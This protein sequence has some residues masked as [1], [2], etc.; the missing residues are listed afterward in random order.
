MNCTILS[1]SHP[2]LSKLVLFLL[3]LL[4]VSLANAQHRMVDTASYSR[5]PEIDLKESSAF[6]GSEIFKLSVKSD[7]IKEFVGLVDLFDEVRLLRIVVDKSTI[8]M[9]DLISSIERM[10]SLEQLS[11]TIN[12][13]GPIP[14]EL[15][16]LKG[17]RSLII[18]GKKISGLPAEI[19]NLENLES[20]VLEDMKIK[21]L[22]A[23]V[24][25]LKNLKS[26]SLYGIDLTDLSV[27][28]TCPQLT[29]IHLHNNGYSKLPE[30][31]ALM[32]KLKRLSIEAN[33]GMDFSQAFFSL[34]S[35]P[36]LNVLG[37]RNNKFKSLPSTI[38]QVRSLSILDLSSNEFAQL[39]QEVLS[40][41]NL[42]QLIIRD[43]S[44]SAL[45]DG[46]TQLKKLSTL[47]LSGNKFTTLPA[48]IAGMPALTSLNMDRTNLSDL[49][50]DLG[51][52]Q[53]LTV[54]SFIGDKKLDLPATL[55]SL[56]QL[57]KLEDL[58]MGEYIVSSLPGEIGKLSHLKSL[59]IS[60][61]LKTL[62]TEL[63]DLVTLEEL[64]LNDNKLETLPDGIRNLKKLKILDLSGNMLHAF[65][66]MLIKLPK[67]EELTLADNSMT[68]ISDYGQEAGAESP[69]GFRELKYLDLSGNDKLLSDDVVSLIA[70]LPVFQV[71]ISDNHMEYRS[72]A[73]RAFKT[74]NDKETQK[75]YA[76][77]LQA[78]TKAI[79]LNPALAEAYCERG[80]VTLILGKDFTSALSDLSM[81]IQLDSNRSDFFKYRGKIY[82]AL[83]D[84]KAAVS[85]YTRAIGLNGNDEASLTARA[86]IRYWQMHDAKG[87]IADYTRA[88]AINSGAAATYTERGKVKMDSG[89]K[90]AACEDWKKASELSDKDATELLK[91]KCK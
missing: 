74:G 88:I 37:L 53:Q 41:E 2:L 81:A 65:P 66:K 63:F 50:P 73:E 11:I 89:D 46:F 68:S 49:G 59:E 79:T 39:P 30:A 7:D 78:F 33:P 31:I 55:N 28:S 22:P 26:L 90:K 60:F 42:D 71:C 23:E 16:N 45:P 48:V 10:K 43:N 29:E 80:K 6:S 13:P 21:S 25:M 76:G 19:G 91:T 40:L 72:E 1:S 56:A 44:L 84:F 70:D 34:S 83:K 75:E 32:T 15:G 86:S 17:L 35:M 3:F 54:L 12:L 18:A 36:K 20:L 51:K 14:A 24:G 57:S 27:F 61:G 69:S 8:E 67:L 64:Y 9:P 5:M 77:A 38:S 58:S 62:P 4:P 87:S 52:M 82:T 47:D 85:D